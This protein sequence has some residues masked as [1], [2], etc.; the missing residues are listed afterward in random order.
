M[1]RR[2]IWGFASLFL[3]F[4]TF[5]CGRTHDKSAKTGAGRIALV[6]VGDAELEKPLRSAAS[7][8][9]TPVEVVVA[10]SRELAHRVAGR[11]TD[12]V[13]VPEDVLSKLRKPGK[14]RPFVED[15]L[16]VIG[17]PQSPIP[18]E[19]P[20]QLAR[21]GAA[22][23]PWRGRLMVL[24]PATPVGAATRSYLQSLHSDDGKSVW[25]TLGDRRSSAADLEAIAR[26]VEVTQRM[27]G[28]V[29]ASQAAALA[30]KVKVMLDLGGKG[31]PRFRY[32][33]AVVGADHDKLAGELADFLV[34]P[35]QVALFTKQGWQRA[36][37]DGK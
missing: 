3:A 8:Y 25:E 6:V 12:V 33:V 14:P 2:L 9:P 15:H 4:V 20:E 31:A 28:I 7:R 32:D 27:L 5:S 11:P 17:F 26:R 21:L 34:A 22:K 29:A 13:V 18:L 10:P 24:D 35:A 23:P 36:A 30:G 1:H 16:V 37:G 19:Q